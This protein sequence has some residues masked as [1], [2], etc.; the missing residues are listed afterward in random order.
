MVLSQT[1]LDL[2][3]GS[4]LSPILYLIYVNDLTSTVDRNNPSVSQYAD[5]VNLYCTDRSAKVA[6]THLQNAL[7]NVIQWCRKWQ[8]Q[9]NAGKSQVVIFFK[10]S[11]TQK[12]NH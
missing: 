8:V 9:M 1:L 11:D 2:K 4:C 6:K 7:D 3:Q 5:D 12:Q 10:M